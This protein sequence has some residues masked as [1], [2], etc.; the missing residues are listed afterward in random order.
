MSLKHTM[1]RILA[2][3]LELN[4]KTQYLVGRVPG[5]KAADWTDTLL[6]HTPV[7]GVNE[8]PFVQ[9]WTLASRDQRGNPRTATF[10]WNHLQALRA[11]ALQRGRIC[12]AFAFDDLVRMYHI[13]PHSATATYCKDTFLRDLMHG[14][15]R[16]YIAQHARRPRYI[17]LRVPC[18]YKDWTEDKIAYGA[19]QALDAIPPQAGSIRLHS[20]DASQP[21]VVYEAS[22]V[23]EVRKLTPGDRI[24]WVVLAFDDRVWHTRVSFPE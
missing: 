16:D 7:F 8:I 22:C 3:H 17:L 23:D 4:P 1:E 11:M 20:M 19:M 13:D 5:C 15:A 12:M 10:E 6:Y 14:Y 18:A 24:T 21:P 2:G 9:T